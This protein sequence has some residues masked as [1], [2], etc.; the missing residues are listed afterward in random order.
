V[1]D[2]TDDR[3]SFA[4]NGAETDT[5]EKNMSDE[6]AP[7][8]DETS[9]E[10]DDRDFAAILAEFESG[11]DA[12]VLEK[13]PKPGE[14]VSG[15]VL[16]IGA[17][18]VFVDV[19]AKSDAVVQRAEF[20]DEEG[21]L[22]IEVGDSVEGLITGRDSSSGCLILRVRSG[23][24][25][26]G[27]DTALAMDELA[28]AQ[29]SGFPVEGTVI[30]VVKGGV[31]VTV[32]GLRAFCPISQLELSYVEDATGYI[33]QKLSFI[34]RNFT[35]PQR[36]RRPDIVLSRR[37]LLEKEKKQRQEEALA[38]LKE[39]AEV[40]GTI[41]SVTSYGAFVD[42]GGVEGLIHV[43][44]LDHER[45]NDPNDVVRSGERV[46]VKVLSIQERTDS[47][48]GKSGDSQGKGKGKSMRISL[49]RRALQQDP[50]A[51]VATRFKQDQIV[52]GR[53]MRIEA[54]G[55]FIRLSQ[56][57]EGL[58]HISELASDRRISHPREVVDLG[59]D[60]EVK[61]LKVE[62]ER[63]R[64]S[65]SLS[66]IAKDARTASEKADVEAYSGRKESGKGFGA[67][68]AFFEKAKK[69]D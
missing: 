13:D 6:T 62:P 10:N 32:A 25:S 48:D 45:V 21:N 23:G 16:T 27:A 63:R 50:W 64:I 68:A 22:S 36:G 53:V 24:G 30:E 28:Q 11:E 34:V 17:D 59:Q 29:A 15:Q 65:V 40:D 61:I 69:D 52:Q 44:E 1:K 67:M 43:S 14:K 54:F 4:T 60:V 49:S 31:Q 58:A 2:A 57:I 47:K 42:L 5:P 66:A 8:T 38:R 18:S 37:S 3:N 7:K 26:G 39:G 9:S 33:G 12:V 55:A 46:R 19:G 56:G 41:T 35:P 51:N 20:E